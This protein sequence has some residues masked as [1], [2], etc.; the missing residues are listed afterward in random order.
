MSAKPHH[1]RCTS[2]GSPFLRRSRTRVWERPLRILFLRPYRC[3]E[4]GHRCYVSI[5]RHGPTVQQQSRSLSE[6]QSPHTAG[7]VRIGTSK[8]W[9][10]V[11]GLLGCFCI[12]AIASL[13]FGNARLNL[14]SPGS[15][16]WPFAS[17]GQAHDESLTRE[18]AGV[19]AT[20]R[21]ANAQP[22]AS[23]SSLRK[24]RRTQTAAPIQSVEQLRPLSH[25][26]NQAGSVPAE[27]IRAERPKVPVDIQSTITNDNIVKVRV[28]I[29]ES[30]RVIDATIV[31][32]TGPV[33]T[34]LERYSLDTAR[35]WRFR[36]ARNNGKAVGSDRVLEFLF[37][38]SDT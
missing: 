18:A 6:G 25:P 3:R 24:T 10:L 16:Q 22:D 31:S 32:A 7:A 14:R 17:R 35:R 15:L 13:K 33:A 21:E 37:R 26:E 4:C 29:D 27:A 12:V 36:P 34:S 20:R 2:C 30:G 9:M 11:Y 23:P 1:R 5:W 38:P 28:W 19:K 8:K